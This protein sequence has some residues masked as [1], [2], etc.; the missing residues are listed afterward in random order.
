MPDT[1][2]ARDT[3]H[4]PADALGRAALGRLLAIA[5]TDTGQS[6]CVADFLLA[7][8]N[9]RACGGFDPTA[10]WRLEP[11]IRD[12]ILAV[13]H[14]IAHHREQP[15]AYGHGKAFEALVKRWRPGLEQAQR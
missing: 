4:D 5:Q 11:P 1:S 14:M 8:W 3:K 2:P 15:T 9:E 7:W 13:L 6:R 12:D 10:L